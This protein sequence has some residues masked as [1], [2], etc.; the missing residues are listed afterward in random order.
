MAPVT[1]LAGVTIEVPAGKTVALVGPSGA[2]K[3]T[4]LR[5]LLRLADRDL[6]RQILGP[7]GYRR[8]CP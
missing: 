6:Y 2:G 1:A 8:P 4:V 3:S 5:L 7:P